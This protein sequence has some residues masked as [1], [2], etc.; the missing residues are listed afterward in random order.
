M[1]SLFILA[2][3]VVVIWLGYRGRSSK[4][5]IPW[6]STDLPFLGS[7]QSYTK[8]PVRF[9]LE[10]KAKLGDIFRVDLLV[11]RV[12]FLIGPKVCS[13]G[14]FDRSPVSEFYLCLP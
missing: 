1:A 9:L 13:F 3:F 2:V 4:T 5:T 11:L 7:A 14:F 10:Q 6:T 12:T 8:D